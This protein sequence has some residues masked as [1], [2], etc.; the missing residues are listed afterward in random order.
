[1]D[2]ELSAQESQ[3][4]PS[5]AR[6]RSPVESIALVHQVRDMATN[7]LPQ[8]LERILNTPEDH[9]AELPGIRG[10]RLVDAV[11]AATVL[12]QRRAVLE[13]A[14][15]ENLKREFRQFLAKPSAAA[16]DRGVAAEDDGLRTQLLALDAR[17]RILLETAPDTPITNP[18][19][20]SAVL[21]AFHDACGCLDLDAVGLEMLE[22][23]F[24]NAL[25]RNLPGICQEINRHLEQR[26]VNP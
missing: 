19:R 6:R 3:T 12:R 2:A 21:R 25:D 26:Q 18:M 22:Q 13:H 5:S 9:I 11:N 16:P 1:M 4:S 8:M 20:R 10:K 14:F 15:I 17:M 7:A 23:V 24:S